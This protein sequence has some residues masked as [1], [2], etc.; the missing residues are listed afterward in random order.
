[1]LSFG[2][3][4]VSLPLLG[5]PLMERELC[6]QGRAGRW[7]SALG[8]LGT[9]AGV[10]A[11][12]APG[13]L[14]EAGAV[15]VTD[16]ASVSAYRWVVEAVADTPSWVGHFFEIAT[17]GTLVV[18]GALLLWMWWSAVR[19]HDGRRSAGA[20]L[21]G[22][23]TVAGYAISEAVKL[24]VDEERPCRALRIGTAAIA[25]C[26]EVGD[27][28]FPSNHAT[29][30]T[31]LAV[32]LAM[33]WRRLAALTLSVAVAAALLRVLVG[34]HYPHDVLAGATLGGA[35]VGAVLLA[36]LPFAERMASRLG[37]HRRNDSGLMSHNRGSGSIVHGQ[38]PEYGAH[39]GLDRPLHHMEP[40]GDLGVGQPAPE[41]GEHVPLPRGEGADP[42]TGG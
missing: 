35:V 38:T 17:E 24:V 13:G 15:E 8:V 30:A 34:V 3:G 37:R 23:G 16:G 2:P 10:V 25:E 6:A 28:S 32:G 11:W 18:L 41:V 9:G 31:G 27:W 29:L 22:V 19:R 12:L 7:V 26:P 14:G 20:V 5:F 39:M 1:M 40:S 36:G 42:V 33:L 4:S 21:I